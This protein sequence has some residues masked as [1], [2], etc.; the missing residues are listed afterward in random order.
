MSKNS[1]KINILAE[2]AVTPSDSFECLPHTVNHSYPEV[3]AQYDGMEF[4]ATE[5]PVMRFDG[6]DPIAA[7]EN[8]NGEHPELID[9]EV[10]DNML[11]VMATTLCNAQMAMLRSVRSEGLRVRLIDNIL[12]SLRNNFE[13]DFEP[14]AGLLDIDPDRVN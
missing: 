11:A 2:I 8:E 12:H 7:L 6:V 10:G 14:E 3:V 1:L 13:S 5:E 9:Q 4:C